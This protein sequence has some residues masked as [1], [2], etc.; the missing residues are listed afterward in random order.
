MSKNKINGQGEMNKK[1]KVKEHQ[2]YLALINLT[3]LLR[4]FCKIMVDKGQKL[5]FSNLQMLTYW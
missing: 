2:K 4:A 3:N 5:S 1:K